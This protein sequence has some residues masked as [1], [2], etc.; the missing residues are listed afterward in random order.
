MRVQTHTGGRRK[1]SRRLTAAGNA[2]AKSRRTFRRLLAAGYSEAIEQTIGAWL[3][4]HGQSP[5]AIECF[6]S[7]V[8]TSA[9][10]ET[11]DHASLAAAQQVFRDGFLASRGAGDLLLPRLP[12]REIFHDRLLQWLT[13][14]GIL[15]HLGT[16]VRRVEG[17]ARRADA[18]VLP[19]GTRKPFERVI[20]AVPWHRVRPLCAADLLAA[21]SAMA[22]VER[23]EPA[24]ITAV[25]LWFDR[26]VVPLPHAVL[27]GRLG[28]WVFAE[29]MS[30]VSPLPLGEGTAR[31]QHCQVVVSAS[32]R[33]A[34]R[35]HD[36][37]LAAVRGEL[38]A[39]WPAVRQ[40]RLLHGRVIAQPA[41]V[42]SVQPGVDRFRPPQRTP[43]ANLALAGDWTATGWPAT[44]ESAVRSGRR[45]V[46]ALLN[47]G[48][49]S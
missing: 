26:P 15:V 6:W 42:F 9:L 33:L 49:G 11:V 46:G 43:V 37:W 22:D 19:D 48:G 31:Q 13:A 32:H 34:R 24:A 12:L 14:R 45:A 39:V 41:A 28:Q 4:A 16:A 17:D 40:A 27:V 29:S 18:L 36:E 44:M 8:L 38:E 7:V 23:I 35:K 21:M 2:L 30:G 20:V 47:R 10:G 5:R 25:H 1:N 3:R